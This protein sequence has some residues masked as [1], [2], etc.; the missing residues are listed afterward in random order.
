MSL[1]R[2]RCYFFLENIFSVSDIDNVSLLCSQLTYEGL[3]AE[4]FGIKSG[5]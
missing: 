1:Q 2:G 3:V 5:R 4:T